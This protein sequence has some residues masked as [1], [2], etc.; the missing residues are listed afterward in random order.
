MQREIPFRIDNTS[1]HDPKI[2][3]WFV[4][5]SLA[6]NNSELTEIARYWFDAM[7]NCSDEVREVFHDGCP[8]VCYG[9]AAFAYVNVFSAHVNVGFYQGSTLADPSNLLL[10][11]GKYMRHVKISPNT[12]INNAALHDLIEQAYRDVKRMVELG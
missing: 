8:V 10:G 12:P 2:E 9:D 4:G 11:S 6:S 7:R 1:E 5:K 3:A